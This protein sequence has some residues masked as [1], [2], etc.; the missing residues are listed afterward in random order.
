M[1]T[2]CV[3]RM[4][5]QWWSNQKLA[6]NQSALQVS[7]S[8]SGKKGRISISSP[9]LTLCRAGITANLTCLM[10]LVLI[11]FLAGFQQVSNQS[12]IDGPPILILCYSKTSLAFFWLK[13]LNWHFCFIDLGP[14]PLGSQ[15][16]KRVKGQ[17]SF[18]FLKS[19]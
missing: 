8:F 4:V 12:I 19:L 13:L 2:Y 10:K 15:S 9:K 6:R 3:V 1:N 14:K 17:A 11:R 16:C 7:G 5:R 18:L